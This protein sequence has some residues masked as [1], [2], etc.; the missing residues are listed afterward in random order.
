LRRHSIFGEF[1]IVS[2]LRKEKDFRKLIE[3]AI[4]FP[5]HTSQIFERSLGRSSKILAS[6]LRVLNDYS[7]YKKFI[8]K[9]LIRLQIGKRVND[10]AGAIMLDFL[11]PKEIKKSI[12]E[13]FKLVITNEKNS[14]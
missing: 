3:I 12:S 7:K 2:L 9:P 6:Y 8:R 4:Q 5:D 1:Y 11:T 10:Y 14:N 13:I